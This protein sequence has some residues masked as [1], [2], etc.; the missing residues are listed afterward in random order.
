M[1]YF[2]GELFDIVGLVNIGGSSVA[3]I[4]IS[5]VLVAVKGGVFGSV[6]VTVKE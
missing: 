1:Y 5:K 4:L 3:L 2:I 6:A